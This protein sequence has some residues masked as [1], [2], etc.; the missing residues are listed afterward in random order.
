[1]GTGGAS[2]LDAGGGEIERSRNSST[3]S[4][5]ATWGGRPG[6]SQGTPVPRAPG[7]DDGS[8]LNITRPLAGRR[9]RRRPGCRS[10]KR[11][12]GAERGQPAWG[13]VPRRWALISSG[14]HHPGGVA[15]QSLDVDVAKVCQGG[16]AGEAIQWRRR[17][18]LGEEAR[19]GRS[20]WADS[21]KV[22]VL[23]STC[24]WATRG[25]GQVLEQPDAVAEVGWRRPPG[26]RGSCMASRRA[27]DLST[28]DTGR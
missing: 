8:Q 19:W 24:H 5:G 11:A 21:A 28:G 16:S 13:G 15:A 14:G 27:G 7:G 22:V 4:P 10:A 20:G 26:R 1:M 2:G 23:L 9:G 17:V 6:R 18:A 25:E 3:P 12:A